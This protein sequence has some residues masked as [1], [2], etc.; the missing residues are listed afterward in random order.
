MSRDVLR[1]G[2]IGWFEAAARAVLSSTKERWKPGFNPGSERRLK[3]GS[4]PKARS[5]ARGVNP[6]GCRFGSNPSPSRRGR[7]R[8]IRWKGMESP[9][10]LPS[11]APRSGHRSGPGVRAGSRC[12]RCENVGPPKSRR[13]RRRSGRAGRYHATPP[14]LGRPVGDRRGTARQPGGGAIERCWRRRT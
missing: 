4:E 14:W 1:C 6:G 7:R 9:Q 13:T 5:S 12:P 2:A 8:R 3:V 10:A 11:W